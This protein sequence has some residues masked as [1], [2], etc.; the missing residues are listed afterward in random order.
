M[1]LGR[2]GQAIAKRASAFDMKIS[3]TARTAKPELAY[4]YYPSA[5]ALAAEVDF[6]L[7][8]TPGGAETKG[9][10]NMEVF[11]ALGPNGYFIN[12]ARGSVVDQPAMLKALQDKIIAGAGLDVYYDEPRIS[13]EIRH[14]PNVVL[15]PHM[16]S[17]T[18]ETR[19]AM[20]DLVLGNLAA[21]FAGKEL[22]TPVPEC[23]A[24][25]AK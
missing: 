1:G 17:G 22:L 13:P 4:P 6:L 21:Y 15:T 18:F 20:A 8:I 3:Y 10:I 14:L 7:A 5:K 9:L 25:L 16:A 11:E 24:L 19:R 2:I 23:Q 12:V